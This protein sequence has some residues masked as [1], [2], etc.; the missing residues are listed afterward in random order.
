MLNAPGLRHPLS[1]P[2]FQKTYLVNTNHDV[3]YGNGWPLRAVP[4]LPD[5]NTT[6]TGFPVSTG[7]YF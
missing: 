3:C 5:F 7:K 6:A 4:R 2:P 1:P